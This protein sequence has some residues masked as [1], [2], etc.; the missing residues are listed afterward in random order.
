MMN[1]KQLQGMMPLFVAIHL[2]AV[3]ISNKHRELSEAYFSALGADLTAPFRYVGLF[4]MVILGKHKIK[5]DSDFHDACDFLQ[6]LFGFIWTIAMIIF[7]L[8]GLLNIG[9]ISPTFA[10]IRNCYIPN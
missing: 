7:F 1:E 4:F 6:V 9:K 2:L 8:I 3:K 10:S 5:D